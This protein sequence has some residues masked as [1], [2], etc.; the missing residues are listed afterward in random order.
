MITLDEL[1]ALRHAMAQKKTE[2][3][4]PWLVEPANAEVLQISIEF[5][6]QI[7]DKIHASEFLVCRHGISLG[8]KDAKKKS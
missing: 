5:I 4:Q 8:F 7:L 1:L 3:Y 6:I 2:L